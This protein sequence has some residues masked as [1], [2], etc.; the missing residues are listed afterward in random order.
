MQNIK[1]QK[2]YLKALRAEKENLE[3]QIIQT[4]LTI[5]HQEAKLL[6]LELQEE[7]KLLK[8]RIDENAQKKTATQ[9]MRELFDGFEK[10]K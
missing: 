9:V 4:E 3:Q 1:A 6:Q 2:E 5:T 7:F 10:S 8:K